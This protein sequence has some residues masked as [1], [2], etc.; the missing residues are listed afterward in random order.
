MEDSGVSSETSPSC[1]QHISGDPLSLCS[2]TDDIPS[3]KR[4]FWIISCN[5][6]AFQENFWALQWLWVDLPFSSGQLNSFRHNLAQE[7][8]NTKGL[9]FF[10]RPTLRMF[11]GRPLVAACQH[12]TSFFNERF[13]LSPSS[14]GKTDYSNRTVTKLKK[15][16]LVRRKNCKTLSYCKQSSEFMF[17]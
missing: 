7:I 17:Q 4:A 14:G 8:Q 11:H 16:F 15:Y 3:V 1:A 12:C 13:S 6:S 9:S 10:L 5:I 2:L